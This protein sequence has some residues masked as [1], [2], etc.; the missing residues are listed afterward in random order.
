MFKFEERVGCVLLL[1][2][3]AILA[4]IVYWYPWYLCT[5]YSAPDDRYG[6]ALAYA[7]PFWFIGPAFADWA[8]LRLSRAAM[9]AQRT[10]GNGLLFFSVV[11]LGLVGFSPLVV[12]GWTTIS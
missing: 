2:C 10:L 8:L 3:T 4:A 11:L 9:Q 5:Y 6:F 7:F 1:G 12:F